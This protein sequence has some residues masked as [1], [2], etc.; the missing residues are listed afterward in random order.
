MA[1]PDPLIT[2]A[3]QQSSYYPKYLEMVAENTKKTPQES[4][5]VQPAT[6]QDDEAQQESIPLE[7]D[8]D[9]DLE[10]AKKMSLE[11]HQE[12][13]E[14]EGDDADMERA[15][16]LSLDPAFLPQGRAPV[17]GVMI[18][19]PVSETTSKLHEVVGKG[20]PLRDQTPHNSTLDPLPTYV[21]H[22]MRN[23]EDDQEKSKFREEFDSTIPDPSHQTVTSTPPCQ[24]WSKRSPEVKKTDPLP[25]VFGFIRSQVHTYAAVDQCQGTK[26]MMLS[27]R[28]LANYHLYHALMEALIADE[29]AM[30]KEVAN[31][32]KD[33]KR[34]HDSDDDEDDDDERLQLDQTKKP[35]P[36]SE[37]PIHL[38]QNGH[39]HETDFPEQ[40]NNKGEITSHNVKVPEENKLH[41]KTMILGDKER[42]IALSIS[43][44]K[45]TRY[46]NDW[47]CKKIKFH[48]YGL[49]SEREYDI[50]GGL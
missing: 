38:N 18:R 13:G 37:R 29:D 42:T 7:E 50:S 34:K 1:I 6:K 31:K 39:S 43:K 45:A 19:D 16:K 33:H 15:I 40:E 41:R 25:D 5:S 20:K 28:N 36:E 32:V 21:R 2:E 4:A 8:D 11:A 24:D 47:P 23:P 48:H 10:M 12:K 49:K 17:G 26:L 9:P 14:G 30:D 35:I 27:L 46:R 44:H 3:I 22:I